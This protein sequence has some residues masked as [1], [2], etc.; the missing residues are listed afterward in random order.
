MESQL[1]VVLDSFRQL[2][3]E[4]LQSA[5][6]LGF[7][8]V[9]MPAVSGPVAPTELTG[10]GRRHLS[11]FVSSLGLELSALGGDL[12][13]TRFTDSS[14]LEQSLEKTRAIL[15][16]ARDLRV[17]V[18]TTH[19]GP[20]TEADLQEGYLVEAVE[21]LADWSDRTG[22]FV[23][24]ETAGADPARFADLLRRI[25][26]PTLGMCYDPASLLIDGFEPLAGIEPVANT[27]LLA[28]ARDALAGSSQ[29]PGREVPLGEGQID[30]P[31]YLA[32]LDQAG[33]RN[34]PFIRRTEARRP[35]EELADAK[36]KLERLVR[37]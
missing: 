14:K 4:A 3:R 19:L 17:P 26:S 25:N 13:G 32:A 33:Y 15:E 2:P 28:R 36:R 9:E 31:E 30:W 11:K 16:M 6:Q 29:R 34:V 37:A 35:L 23:A 5:A 1:G 21:Q 20:I 8:K 22:T 12:G 18:V 24:F 27:I 10:T 7:R